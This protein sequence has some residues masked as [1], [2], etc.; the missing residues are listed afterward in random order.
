MLGP[1]KKRGT[2]TG[3]PCPG[4]VSYYTPPHPDRES[5]RE[6]GKAGASPRKKQSQNPAI[7]LVS[8]SPTLW[9]MVV[10]EQNSLPPPIGTCPCQVLLEYFCSLGLPWSRPLLALEVISPGLP[11]VG[12]SSARPPSH[13]TLYR[14]GLCAQGAFGKRQ[15]SACPGARIRPRTRPPL[16]PER[17]ARRLLLPLRPARSLAVSSASS[18]SPREFPPPPASLVSSRAGGGGGSGEAAASRF[19]LSFPRSF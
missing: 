19:V 13:S 4:A 15:G 1:D 10:R 7:D 12:D 5:D 3:V 2:T 16:Q 9:H 18:G 8:Q 14:T 6:G 11:S 17:F